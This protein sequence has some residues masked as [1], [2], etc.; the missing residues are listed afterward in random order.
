ME[1]STYCWH[2]NNPSEESRM[3]GTGGSSERGDAWFPLPQYTMHLPQEKL[4]SS[5]SSPKMQPVLLYQSSNDMAM[6]YQSMRPS[7]CS[8]EHNRMP[9]PPTRH[10]E[11]SLS[12]VMLCYAVG[13]LGNNY[14]IQIKILLRWAVK[15]MERHTKLHRRIVEI[16]W[17]T[18][19]YYC[20]LAMYRRQN[21]H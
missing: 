11:A 16:C 12:S 15:N 5:I 7:W 1:A 8:E 13:V 17:A 2:A 21:S 20:T 19:R 6:T 9:S 10:T 14:S 18:N 4:S 3:V